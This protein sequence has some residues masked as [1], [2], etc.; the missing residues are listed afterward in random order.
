LRSPP[1]L[2]AYAWLCQWSAFL[3]ILGHVCESCHFGSK[4]TA[5]STTLHWPHVSPEASPCSLSPLL[6][7]CSSEAPSWPHRAPEHLPGAVFNR[8][9]QTKTWPCQELLA[10]YM[11][12]LPCPRWQS[13]HLANIDGCSY[14]KV[15]SEPHRKGC[16]QVLGSPSTLYP[17]HWH[18]CTLHS[19]GGAYPQPLPGVLTGCFSMS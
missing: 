5:K 17:A 12:S 19:R 18:Y 1:V 15:L 10:C 16:S 9:F 11:P 6:S 8:A 2:K 7:T 4:V 3:R 13:L 14:S